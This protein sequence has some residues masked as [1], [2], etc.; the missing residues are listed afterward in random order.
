MGWYIRGFVQWDGIFMGYP[1][2]LVIILVIILIDMTCAGIY[3]LAQTY[4]I[5]SS[6]ASHILN[7]HA[8]HANHT[9]S[10]AMPAM[11]AIH[12]HRVT[13]KLMTRMMTRSCAC[14]VTL[15]YPPQRCGISH[16]YI[17]PWDSPTNIPY[18]G[19]IVVGTYPISVKRY[20]I[21]ALFT[22]TVPRYDIT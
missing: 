11:P 20:G 16:K 18:H 6:H 22:H 8:S 7:S 15:S 2:F 5:L 17:I 21:Q 3:L 12:I 13:V 4:Y 14:L 9:D 1:I 19:M 10:V